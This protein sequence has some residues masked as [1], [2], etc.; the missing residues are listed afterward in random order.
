VTSPLDLVASMVLDSG[1]RWGEEATPEQWADMEALLSP[2]GP[3]RHFWLR[4]RGRSKTFDAGAAT[5]AMMLAGGLG[6][7]DEAY[8]AAAGRDQA[9]LLMRKVRAIAEHTPE[10]AGAV[11]IQNYRLITPRTGAELTVISADLAS[12]WGRTPR[13]L[14]VDEIAN[15]DR[16]ESAQT[17]IES[18]LTSLPKRGDSQALAAT[19]PSSPSHWSH[20]LWKTA[21][22]DPL[23]RASLTAGPAPWQSEAELESERRRLPESLWRRLFLCEW[24]E[25]DDALADAAAVEAC[26][27]HDGPLSPQAGVEYIVSFDLSVSHDHTAVV[28]AHMEDASGRRDVVVD[29][30]EAWIP[31]GG[32][33][34]DLQDVEAYIAQAARDYNGAQ[35][36]GD[37]YQ[38][39]NM[40]QRLRD[41]GLR[42][43]PVVFTAVTNS[44][45]A[46]MLLRLIRD[47]AL[48]LPDDAAL[49]KELLSL[50]LAGGVTPGTLK[51]TTDGSSGGHHDRATA[52]MLAAEEMLSRPG[53]SWMDVHG[54]RY[55]SKC[56]QAHPVRQEQCP[57][58]HAPNPQAAARPASEPAGGP[59]GRGEAAKPVPVQMSGWGAAILPLDAVQC[60][61]A[62][63]VYNGA[64]HG[65][66]CPQCIAGTLGFLRGGRQLGG[67]FGGMGGIR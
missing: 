39:A 22:E 61:A 54:M 49:R 36:V 27:R 44:R 19:T 52:L 46:Q 57:R 33:Q 59:A 37:M 3:R 9:A 1:A 11:E 17:F 8:A 23:W 60:A 48:D 25:A 7:G 28:V 41:G 66:R 40:V 21:L 18:L 31:H 10:L 12:S 50:R 56:K 63:H 47:Q 51:L 38:A 2:D 5:L 29:R 45:R 34:V 32:R 67:G 14:F 65:D 55:C 20:D 6:G 58:C 64:V 15:H 24:A 53:G 35:V 42:V 43:K 4:A 26:V 30:L 62:G 13:W 16:G